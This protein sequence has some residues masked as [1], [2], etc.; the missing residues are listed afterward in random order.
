[1]T[2]EGQTSDDI[3]P[4]KLFEVLQ[5]VI[6]SASKDTPEQ[7][8]KDTPEQATPTLNTIVDE[9]ADKIASHFDEALKALQRIQK[10]ILLNVS[11]VL[12]G[13]N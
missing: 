3:S 12:L 5:G 6:D 11:E 7:A 9:V 8:P 4:G 13:I 10:D 2:L 1:M